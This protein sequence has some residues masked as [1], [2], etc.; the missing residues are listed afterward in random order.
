M[1][2]NLI[3]WSF[4]FYA[5]TDGKGKKNTHE[6]TEEMIQSN[7]F[8]KKALDNQTVLFFYLV[9]SSSKFKA[10]EA[11]LVVSFQYTHWGILNNLH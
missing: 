9:L 1:N 6:F 5:I 8:Y 3:I 2:A 7:S 4:I 10:A 11:L